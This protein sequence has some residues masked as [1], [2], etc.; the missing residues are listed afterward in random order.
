MKKSTTF[1]L[2]LNASICL[3]FAACTPNTP[4]TTPTET[5]VTIVKDGENEDTM[6]IAARC[7]RHT[8]QYVFA[9]KESFDRCS[10]VSIA[11][12][13]GKPLA[14]MPKELLAELDCIGTAFQFFNDRY[15]TYMNGQNVMLYDMNTNKS[16]LLFTAFA[17]TQSNCMGVSPDGT[18]LLF[19]NVF[20][21]DDERKKSDY[22]TPTRIMVVGFDAAK[23]V[24]TTKQKFDRPV[25][26]VPNEGNM[27]ERKDCIFADDK[28]VRYRELKVDKDGM[29]TGDGKVVDI[30]L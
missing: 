18:K 16:L 9:D 26:W 15:M 1:M 24:V 19:V 2:A 27:I 25:N 10:A 12:K 13:D 3:L 21:N 23:C 4:K 20:E 29:P 11:R 30:A 22:T 7:N 6:T 5:T 8:Q 28:T 17:G 14:K